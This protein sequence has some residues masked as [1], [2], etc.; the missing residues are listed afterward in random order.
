MARFKLQADERVLMKSPLSRIEGELGLKNL[1]T[2]KCRITDGVGFLTTHRIVLATKLVEFP[3]GPLIWLVRS[4]LGRKILFEIPL[5]EIPAVSKENGA[6]F[7][8][9]TISGE[10][11]V[12][13]SNSFFNK[14]ETWVKEISGAL[15]TGSSSVDD[16]SGLAA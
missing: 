10:E 11:I 6:I 16:R 2:G 4:I 15:A 1:I 9:Q 12:L 7:K 5:A 13:T 3:W 14:S 8:L